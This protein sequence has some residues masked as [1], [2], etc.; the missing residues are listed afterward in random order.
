MYKKVIF[1]FSILFFSILKGN[2]QEERQWVK[3]DS[4][5]HNVTN[6]LNGRHISLWASHGR[7]YDAKK[8]V[9]KWLS[10]LDL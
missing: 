2:A 7:Y 10:L 6:G 8:G 9:W 1:V 3:N 4:K 5:P